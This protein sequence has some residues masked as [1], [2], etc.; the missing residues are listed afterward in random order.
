MVV[1]VEEFKE[2]RRT[3]ERFELKQAMRDWVVHYDF[4][5]DILYVCLP[6][7]PKHTGVW[8][9]GG[10]NYYITKKIIS[11]RRGGEIVGFFIEYFKRQTEGEKFGKPK[12]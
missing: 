6:R 8:Y 1:G 5:T 3:I 2:T 11:Q 4:D 7:I 12:K 9:Y 10:I